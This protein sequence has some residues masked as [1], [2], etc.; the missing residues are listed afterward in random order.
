MDQIPEKQ[1]NPNDLIIFQN[2]D[3]ADHEWQFDAINTPIPYRILKGQ[4]RELPYYIAR[5]GIDKLIDKLLMKKGEN[6][7]NPLLRSHLLDEIVLGKKSINQIREKTPQ[8]MAAEEMQRKKDTDPYEELFTRRKIEQE[9]ADQAVQTQNAPIAPLYNIEGTP[10]VQPAPTVSVPVAQP[11]AET[12]TV[13][14]QPV[15]T[16]DPKEVANEAVLDQANPERIRVY[17]FLKTR[18]MLDLSHEKTKQQLDSRPVQSIIDEFKIEFPDI[19][20]PAR[21]LVADT[22]ESLAGEGM[23]VAPTAPITQ[24]TPVAATPPAPAPPTPAPTPTIPMNPSAQ[25]A[26]LLAGQLG[27]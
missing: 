9:R 8:E 2:L 19:V 10:V 22:K 16:T 17:N 4:T 5:H 11:V 27:K 21:Q 14:I 13:A 1:I 6:P 25:G 24:R 18:A 3:D 23:P 20:D 26:P 15:V 12:P 7:T